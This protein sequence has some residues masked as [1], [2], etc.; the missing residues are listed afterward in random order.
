MQVPQPYARL[1]NRHA[2]C[3]S[4]KYSSLNYTAMNKKISYSLLG[5]GL[6]LT[7]VG[8]SCTSNSSKTVAE[9]AAV[10]ISG[11]WI[12]GKDVGNIKDQPISGKINNVEVDSLYTVVEKW[13]DEYTMKFSTKFPEDPCGYAADNDAVSFDSTVFKKGTFY[14]KMED[15]VQSSDYSAFYYYTQADGTPYSVNTDWSGRVVVDSITEAVKM[16]AFNEPVGEVTGWADFMFD[17]G[18]TAVSG[19]FTAEYCD[20]Q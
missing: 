11:S 13:D 12:D 10:A 5:L 16:D 3:Y 18:A 6:A 17:D 4:Q 2:V 8:A 7:L 19:K 1:A 9:P 15:D 20:L 14:K